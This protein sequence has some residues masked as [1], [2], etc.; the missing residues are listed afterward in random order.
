VLALYQVLFNGGAIPVMLFMGALTD[1][2]SITAVINMLVAFCL[3]AALLTLLRVLRAGRGGSDAR[4]AGGARKEEEQPQ[5]AAPVGEESRA[6][7]AHAY[8]P[9]ALSS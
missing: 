2:L 7:E 4:S 1:L 6:Q 9:P 5:Y 3:A 8:E